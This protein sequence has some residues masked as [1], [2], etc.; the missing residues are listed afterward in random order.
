MDKRGARRCQPNA[1]ETEGPDPMTCSVGASRVV[2]MASE[3]ERV[4]CKQRHQGRR[5][6]LGHMRLGLSFTAQCLV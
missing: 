6:G 2:G 1:Q 4:K 3:S 5:P